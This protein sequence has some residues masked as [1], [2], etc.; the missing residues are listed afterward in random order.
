[1]ISTPATTARF[2]AATSH[3]LEPHVFQAFEVIQ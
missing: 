2:T 3:Q 1:M